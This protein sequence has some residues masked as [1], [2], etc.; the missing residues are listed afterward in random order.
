MN[1]REIVAMLVLL[2]PA[3]FALMHQWVRA[4]PWGHGIGA[5]FRGL[6][7]SAVSLGAAL[8]V[9]WPRGWAEFWV[10][11]PLSLGLRPEELTRLFLFALW[12]GLAMRLLVV[13]RGDLAQGTMTDGGPR[14][15]TLTS[16]G[17]APL[18]TSSWLFV[19]GI[20]GYG[21]LAVGVRSFTGEAG[22][23]A[24]PTGGALLL[25]ALG[26]LLLSL[27]PAAVRSSLQEAEP[28]D[29]LGSREL[30]DAYA[31]HRS[32]KTTGYYWLTLVLV[33]WMSLVAV[34]GTWMGESAEGVAVFIEAAALL[35]AI[36]GAAFGIQ[37][38]SGRVRIKHQLDELTVEQ[39]SA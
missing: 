13:V 30:A 2:S 29:P 19:Y 16:R 11:R 9:G 31:V 8:L 12:F 3:L 34:L 26:L 23:L 6:T 28:M 33:T 17:A 32:T 37:M 22:G 20:W 1:N 7:L 25:L 10:V 27:G 4:Q 14:S 39:P 36:G 38:A 35:I 21:A 24:S 15:A 5:A 18:S